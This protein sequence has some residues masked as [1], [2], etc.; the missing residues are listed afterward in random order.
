MI[1]TWCSKYH[2]FV[3]SYS[4]LFFLIGLQCNRF[5]PHGILI[6]RSNHL[7]SFP[8][9]PSRLPPSLLYPSTLR[10][11]ASAFI[12][13]VFSYPPSLK[14]LFPSHCPLS[15]FLEIALIRSHL[16]TH[17]SLEAKVWMSE[18]VGIVFLCLDHL[19]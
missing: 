10:I 2:V 7:P 5:S 1:L 3:V 11:P 8:L 14:P 12:C 16:N 13:H 6:R 4:F 15:C 17:T 9:S 18:L 19:T